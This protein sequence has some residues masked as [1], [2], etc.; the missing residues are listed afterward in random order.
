MTAPKNR[1]WTCSKTKEAQALR[2]VGMKQVQQMVHLDSLSSTSDVAVTQSVSCIHVPS[3][4]KVAGTGNWFAAP[5]RF[6]GIIPLTQRHSRG[7]LSHSTVLLD[8][9]L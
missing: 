4:K 7:M 3:E 6:A 9:H 1:L 5:S 2:H 8:P